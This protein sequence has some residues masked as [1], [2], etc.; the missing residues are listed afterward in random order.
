M[1]TRLLRRLRCAIALWRDPQ[2]TFTW[3]AA[4]RSA[5]RMA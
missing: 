3:R 4:W 5:R 1:I 2:L